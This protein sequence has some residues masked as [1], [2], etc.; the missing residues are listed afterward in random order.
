MYVVVSRATG[1]AKVAI[2]KQASCK[3]FGEPRRRSKDHSML[4]TSALSVSIIV[5]P[6]TQIEQIGLR[7]FEL[8]PPQSLGR[9]W[10]CQIVSRYR[11]NRG[12][13]TNTR[14]AACDK[15]SGR[16]R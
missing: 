7:M 3:K 4:P 15:A 14:N 13:E 2:F 1:S 6:Q 9:C 16:H 11:A 5:G 10:G 8:T 12:D